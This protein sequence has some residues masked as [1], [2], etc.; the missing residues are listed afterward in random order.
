VQ[1]RQNGTRAEELRD[2]PK[3]LVWHEKR[4][5]L[6]G[7]KRTRL[8]LAEEN[9]QEENQLVRTTSENQMGNNP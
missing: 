3:F 9:K 2:G 8:E 7:V 5:P 4:D 1:I 6:A